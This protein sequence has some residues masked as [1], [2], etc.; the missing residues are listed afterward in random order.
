M[1]EHNQTYPHSHGDSVHKCFDCGKQIESN[2]Q[3]IHVGINELERMGMNAP[4]IEGMD[5]LKFPFCRACTQP[6]EH[7][8]QFESH[9][10]K[11]Q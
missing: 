2:E 1:T 11:G 9:A 3:H 7:G 10:V 4:P 6:S 8:W 5:D